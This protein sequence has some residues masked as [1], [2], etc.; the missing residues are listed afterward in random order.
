MSTQQLLQQ[1][2]EGEELDSP[3]LERLMHEGYIEARDVTNMDTPQGQRDYLFM[4]FT[5]KARQVLGL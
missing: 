3:T 2:D 1:L 4:F 5:E